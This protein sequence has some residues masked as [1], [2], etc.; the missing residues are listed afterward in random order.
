MIGSANAGLRQIMAAIVEKSVDFSLSGI[1]YIHPKFQGNETIVDYAVHN[2]WNGAGKL[3][4][5]RSIL[6]LVIN[7]NGFCCL[8]TFF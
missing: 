3:A 8:M 1:A 4:R 5:S 2:S 7:L 6:F